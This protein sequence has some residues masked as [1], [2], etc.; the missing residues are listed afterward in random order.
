MRGSLNRFERS[1]ARKTAKRAPEPMEDS[2]GEHFI[3]THER[4]RA[5]NGQRRALRKVQ[6]L[7]MW[8]PLVPRL[9]PS[10]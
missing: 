8:L 7:R 4:W 9:R 5:D 3:G 10:L 1:E 2:E 6:R